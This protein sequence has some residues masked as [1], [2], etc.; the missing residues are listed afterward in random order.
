MH[1]LIS[2]E[3]PI[4]F[5]EKPYISAEATESHEKS[6]SKRVDLHSFIYFIT[7]VILI[8]LFALKLKID[9]W[10]GAFYILAMEVKRVR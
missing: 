4:D 1:C 3:I 8:A 6:W 7:F 10:T 5:N 2:Q 9:L